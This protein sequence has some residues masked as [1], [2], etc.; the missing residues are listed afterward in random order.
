MSNNSPPKY[1]AIVWTIKTIKQK[2]QT[3]YFNTLKVQVKR[4]K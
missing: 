3:F 1:Q 4:R 2:K